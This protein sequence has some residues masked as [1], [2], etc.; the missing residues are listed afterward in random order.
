LRTILSLCSLYLA[1]SAVPTAS[2]QRQTQE[3]S[4]SPKPPAVRVYTNDDLDRLR[5]YRSETGALDEP[6]IPP[7]P[8]GG[9][10]AGRLDESARAEA[11]WRSQADRLREKL[12]PLRRQ[13]DDLRRRADQARQ[14]PDDRDY[15]RK[16]SASPRGPSA[17]DLGARQRAIEEEIRRRE[18]DLEDRARRAGALP[19]WLR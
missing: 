8:T 12:W 3:V 10:R 15:G 4:P 13:I 18:S 17:E 7:A 6:A 19:G 9:G 5:P 11:Y 14:R 2:Q 16:R 1:L